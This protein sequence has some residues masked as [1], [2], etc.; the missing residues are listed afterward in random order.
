MATCYSGPDR[1]PF[2]L[3]TPQIVIFNTLDFPALILTFCRIPD[4]SRDLN[5]LDV[6]WVGEKG[7]TYRYTFTAPQKQEDDRIA[8]V[9]E[10]LDTFVRVQL[11]GMNILQSEN[12]FVPQHI[13]V[14]HALDF[15][16]SN[17]LGLVF[18]SALLRARDI[19][20]EH[21]EHN[22]F[23]HLG[24]VE[25]LGTRKAPYHWGWDWGPKL[26][27]AGLWRPIRLEKYSCRVV[28]VR[29]DYKL[30]TSLKTCSGTISAQVDGNFDSTARLALRNPGGDV[31]FQETCSVSPAGYVVVPFEIQGPE[32]WFPHGYGLQL[33][34]YLDAEISAGGKILHT[35]TRRVG[36][37]QADLIQETDVYGK[38][39]YFRVN[40]VDVFAGG[41]CWIP[42]DNFT[43]RLS[44]EKYREWI[45][46]MV[47]GNQI[48][49]RQA[50]L[51]PHIRMWLM[52]CL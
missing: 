20:R 6:Q 14:T 44:V 8:L 45:A 11:N 37:R 35:L 38:S 30:N 19:R 48:M 9:F 42:G 27:T 39:F 26:M 33:R 36:F 25:R 12:M 28:D 10:G 13:D 41:N 32:L 49:T 5:E 23:G 47:E 29:V 31:V 51:F 24:E 22:Y 50:F 4:P 46:L 2:G 52:V 17:M 3:D 7:W 40:G 34:Y 1:G 21:P 15:S 18:D 16:A 43:P